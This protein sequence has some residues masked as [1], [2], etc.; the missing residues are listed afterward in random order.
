M[1]NSERTLSPPV[2]RSTRVANQKKLD[3]SPQQSAHTDPGSTPGPRIGVVKSVMTGSSTVYGLPT[4]SD[5]VV[6]DVAGIAPT[7]TS[8]LAT[9][10]EF[11]AFYKSYMSAHGWTFE[12]AYSTLDPRAGV[13]TRLGFTSRQTWCKPTTPITS[14]SI[15]VGSGDDTDHGK[16]A[17]IVLQDLP[18]EETCP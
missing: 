10:A 6:G 9:V 8:R 4:P 18:H 15:S 3:A 16:Q 2:T 7:Y 1:L 12:P 14:V 11:T 5:A 13:A 17:Q